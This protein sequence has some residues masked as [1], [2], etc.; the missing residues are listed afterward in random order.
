MAKEKY[1][2]TKDGQKHSYDSLVTIMEG[3][4]EQQIKE[5]IVILGLDHIID[6]DGGIAPEY[7][8]DIISSEDRFLNPNVEHNITLTGRL[9]NYF[10]DASDKVTSWEWTRDSGDPI[11]D[12][13]WIRNSREIRIDDTDLTERV[14]ERKVIFKLKAKVGEEIFED[15]I[16]FST[17]VT[18]NSV[19]IRQSHSLFLGGDPAE[20][21]LTAETTGVRV[22]NYKWFVND[23]LKNT[24]R[25]FKLQSSVV[26]NGSAVNIRLEVIDTKGILHSDFVS[27]PKLSN[28]TNGEPGVPGPPGEDGQALYTWI[29]YADDDQ[30]TNMSEY[31]TNVDGSFREYMGISSNKTSPVESNDYRDYTWSK[32]I[33]EDGV[34]GENG[35]MWVV[36]SQYPEGINH[37]NEV[38]VHNDPYDETVDEYMVYLGLAYNKSVKEEPDF[39][40]MSM[41]E[42]KDQGF[43]WS[44][45]KGEDGHTGYTLDSD[46]D[47]IAL[48]A[49]SDGNVIGVL[50]GNRANFKLF[51]GNT[52]VNMKDMYTEF[53]VSGGVQ[54]NSSRDGNETENSE[55][56]EVLGMRD[57]T[58]S[59]AL[60]VYSDSE[61]NNELAR[62]SVQIAKF[63]NLPVFNIVASSNTINV[64]PGIGNAA[65]IISPNS[66][67][68]TVSKNTGSTIE[69][70]TEGTLTYKYNFQSGDGQA[71]TPDNEGVYRIPVSNAGNPRSIILQ[72]F[73]PIMNNKVVDRETIPF[74]R[75]GKQGNPG[76]DGPQGPQGPPGIPG[77][78]GSEPRRLNWQEGYT[79][80]NDTRYKDYIY[81]FKEGNSASGWYVVK[82]IPEN[83]YTLA[84]STEKNYRKIAGS[85]PDT[86]YFEKQT[87]MDSQVF[88]TIITDQ[89]NIGGLILRNQK[90]YS[91]AMTS[92]QPNIFINGATG[93]VKFLGAEID[94][95]FFRDVY[96]EKGFLDDVSINDATIVNAEFKDGNLELFSEV[97]PAN[98]N[99][100]A[101]T[102]SRKIANNNPTITFFSNTGD[103]QGT[104]E[105]SRATVEI[106]GGM[107]IDGLLFVL[108][109]L[110]TAS[111]LTNPGTGGP[112][113]PAG[114]VYKDDNGFLK[115]K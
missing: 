114:T 71:V 15:E 47:M 50:S 72:Y 62:T 54:F 89:A 22:D 19:Q 33:G 36:Y 83:E 108:R 16:D 64:V 90:L 56:I 92:N 39:N 14:N 95:S 45:I 94:N 85:V 13:I 21:T 55:W 78:S 109:G 97:I 3:L 10:K 26:P 58:G 66:L 79:Y 106:V 41:T 82:K 105:S 74:V 68:V 102:T 44:K 35:Y 70:T 12:D 20:I 30:G 5:L 48:P 42:F 46:N 88:G 91:Q 53:E 86:F 76:E 37:Q 96:I 51:Y 9:Y 25:T 107:Y 99:K 6:I 29:K 98:S 31:P 67:V 81:F 101:M 34:P 8:A 75:D 113:F 104:W 43:L 73:H 40:S 77:T 84:G 61:A 17:V 1:I 115:V 32:Y 87:V 2:L 57:D 7:S 18:L 103:E 24:A 4:D 111:D 52:E 28:G 112:N 23:V 49:D 69:D 80:Y 100:V 65:D 110:P 59:V 63:K 60:V 38:K 93:E 27:I 11:T